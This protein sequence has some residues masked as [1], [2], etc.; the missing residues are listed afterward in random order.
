MSPTR[1]QLRHPGSESI[2]RQLPFEYNRR[3][4]EVFRE[5]V[6]SVPLMRSSSSDERG[7]R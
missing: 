2:E 7:R 4:N 1:Y 5:L 3:T 6:S